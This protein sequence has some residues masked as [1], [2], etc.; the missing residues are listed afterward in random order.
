MNINICK[1]DSEDTP[2]THSS[3]LIHPI[4]IVIST[5][6]SIMS[7][8]HNFRKNSRG[9]RFSALARRGARK[10]SDSSSRNSRAAKGGSPDGRARRN[11]EIA[12]IVDIGVPANFCPMETA[13]VD[14]RSH[15]WDPIGSASGLSSRGRFCFGRLG[16]ATSTNGGRLWFFSGRSYQQAMRKGRFELG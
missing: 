8:Y 16:P 7:N 1:E 13:V 15:S 12:K 10:I 3:S 2:V 6:R 4:S 5:I 9:S 14:H 11:I